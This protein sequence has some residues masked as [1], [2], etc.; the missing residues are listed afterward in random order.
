M[1]SPLALHSPAAEALNHSP[2]PALRRLQ[3]VETDAE[4]IISGAVSSYYLK[5]MAQ[6]TIRPVLGDR[7]LR[8][9]V[10]VRN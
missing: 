10:V 2:Q 9:R 8:N 4:V 3:V 6:E 7:R 1:S 5:Q